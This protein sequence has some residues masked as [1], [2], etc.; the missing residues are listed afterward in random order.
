ADRVASGERVIR[1]SAEALSRIGD[2]MAGS[3]EAVAR[4]VETA[5]AQLDEATS[6]VASIDS[7]A[8]S[9]RANAGTSAQVSAV[10]EEQGASMQHVTESSQHL[11]DIANR[12][13]G[14]LTR[15]EL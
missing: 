8:R 10:V 4:I 12:L 15:V 3:R 2:E 11:A 7:V 14:A 9:A 6:L 1:S 13:K 5:T